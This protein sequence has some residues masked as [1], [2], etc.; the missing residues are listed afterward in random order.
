MSE[1]WYRKFCYSKY[2]ENTTKIIS[3]NEQ[4]GSTIKPVRK[5]E[6]SA[7]H[8]VL[9]EWF[10]HSSD[11]VPLIDPLHMITFVLIKYQCYVNVFLA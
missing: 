4:I 9:L 7:V 11:K 2:L 8:D 6:R 5:A 10:K 3:T 1:I